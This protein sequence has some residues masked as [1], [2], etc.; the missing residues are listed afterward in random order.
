MISK[1][2]WYAPRVFGFGLRPITWEGWVYVIAAF[3]LFIAALNLPVGDIVRII[4]ASVILIVFVIDSL[5]IMS[6]IYKDLTKTEKK[7]HHIIEAT[8]SNIATI[9]LIIAILYRALIDRVADIPLISVLAVMILTKL[10]VF[11]YL[12]HKR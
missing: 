2:E 3:L 11:M 6:R 10:T 8:T 7:H 12:F 4:I 1:K 5:I 9:G